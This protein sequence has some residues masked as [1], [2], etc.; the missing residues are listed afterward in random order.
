MWSRSAS[1]L[2]GHRFHPT[3]KARSADRS[4]WTAYAPE[5]SAAFPLR[6]LAVRDGLVAQECAV[7]GAAE[8]LDRLHP[9]PD[10]YR[11]LPVHPWQYGLLG[12]DP[13]LRA[14]V[15]R[16]DVLDLGCGGPEFAPTASVRTLYGDGGFLKF[17]L[18]VRI[19]N[20]L[21]KN[22]SYE[23]SGAVALTRLLAPVLDGLA[24][25]FPGTGMLREPAY[26]SLALPGPDG[27]TDLGLLEGFGV[28]VRDGLA[29]QL[30][31]GVTAVAGRRP[32]PT[33]TR[34]GRPSSPG[35]WRAGTSGTP[36]GGGPVTCGCWS[37]RC[38]PPTS[39]TAWSW[40]R[41]CRTC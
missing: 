18:N 29:G 6:L 12:D 16:A 15:E 4:A 26:R 31:P 36:S 34:R 40:N 35:C 33:S 10:G 37:R 1:L 20:C 9:V 30:R 23:L 28:I 38:W 7:P 22:A 14:A 41:T 39:S 8:P 19:T 24:V 32:S 13:L 11:L 2:F 27:G 17:S 3:P 25:R 21:R 5:A